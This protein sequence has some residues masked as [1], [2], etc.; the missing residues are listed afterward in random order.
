MLAVNFYESNRMVQSA[1]KITNDKRMT[2]EE[3]KVKVTE[4][5]TYVSMVFDTI[6]SINCNFIPEYKQILEYIKCESS[7][8]KQAIQM[9][10]QLIDSQIF[11]TPKKK[12]QEQVETQKTDMVNDEYIETS[13]PESTDF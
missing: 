5:F 6:E 4:I 12:I 8:Q 3:K 10:L 2:F 13:I 1:E 7:K 9:C 11:L